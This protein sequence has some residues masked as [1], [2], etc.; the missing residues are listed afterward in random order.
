MGICQEQISQKMRGKQSIYH[1]V[2]EEKAREKLKIL[3]TCFIS[4]SYLPSAEHCVHGVAHMNNAD[5]L[6]ITYYRSLAAVLVYHILQR[7][8][9]YHF[10]LSLN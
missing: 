5:L 9:Q 2:H 1:V 10:I 6:S 8:P 3:K 4:R 7:L